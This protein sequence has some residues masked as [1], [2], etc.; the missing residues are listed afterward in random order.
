[1]MDY[2]LKQLMSDTNATLEPYG[3]TLAIPNRSCRMAH[4]LL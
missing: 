1:M 2:R 4:L 3:L